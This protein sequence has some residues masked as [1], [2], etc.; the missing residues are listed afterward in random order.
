MRNL[1]LFLFVLFSLTVNA[2]SDR[3]LVREGNYLYQQKNFAKAEISYR[4]AL[5]KNKLNSQALYNVGCFLL[6]QNKDSAAIVQFEKASK[7]EHNEFR[8]SKSFHNIGFIC[9]SHKMYEQ[10]I[11]AYK[12]SL[13]LNPKDNET[14]YNLVLCKH[15]LKKHGSKQKQ[16]KKQRQNRQNKDKSGQKRQAQENKS[17]NKQNKKNQSPIEKM[18]KENAEQLLNAAIQE[19]QATQQKLKKSMQ[20]PR[21]KHLLKNW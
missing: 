16:Q 9:Q 13:R 4:K 21:S 18:S 20:Q 6:M 19:E 2:Q 14:R 5:S 17:Q 12:E 1:I 3:R 15:L 11:A 8:K 10:A 7:L